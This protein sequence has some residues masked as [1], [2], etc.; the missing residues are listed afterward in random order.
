MSIKVIRPARAAEFT[1]PGVAL[2]EL[3]AVAT[4]VNGCMS[5]AIEMFVPVDPRKAALL[6]TIR[7]AVME[8]L[9]MADVL[10]AHQPEVK[11]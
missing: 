6:D 8:R 7:E 10:L 11:D 5:N 9:A 4:M 2:H 1:M 3:R